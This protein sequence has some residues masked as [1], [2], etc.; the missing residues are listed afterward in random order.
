MKV[1]EDPVT[2]NVSKVS[3]VYSMRKDWRKETFDADTNI[4]FMITEL[5]NTVEP[6]YNEHFGTRRYSL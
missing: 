1:Q 4:R 6:Q 5:Q 3:I 2:E